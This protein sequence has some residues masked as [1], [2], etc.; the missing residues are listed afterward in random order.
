MNLQELEGEESSIIKD[1]KGRTMHKIEKTYCRRKYLNNSVKF[2]ASVESMEGENSMSMEKQI[3][4]ECCVDELEDRIL[5]DFEDVCS[6][7]GSEF[8]VSD[9]HYSINADF[10]APND[11]IVEDIK[12]LFVSTQDYGQKTAYFHQNMRHLTWER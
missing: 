11:E 10:P 1:G 4:E 3:L 7:E 6:E 12:G 9:S 5:V 2:G 8:Y